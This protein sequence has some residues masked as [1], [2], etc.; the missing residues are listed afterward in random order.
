MR[1]KR[2]TQAATRGW[3][4][5]NTRG[6]ERASD[7]PAALNGPLLARALLEGRE[8]GRDEFRYEVRSLRDGRVVIRTF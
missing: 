4:R 6:G 8:Q 3:K 7:R 1:A 5:A 2:H